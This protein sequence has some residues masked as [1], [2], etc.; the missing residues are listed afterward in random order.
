MRIKGSQ[1]I[2]MTERERQPERRTPLVPIDKPLEDSLRDLVAE[3]KVRH[4]ANDLA[5][6]A[7]ALRMVEME[8][9]V[10]GVV[11]L[12]SFGKG[13]MVVNAL[14]ILLIGALTGMFMWV[15]NDK[16]IDFR[17]V[18]AAIQQQ[19]VL[20][21]TNA[22]AEKI[23]AETLRDVVAEQKRTSDYVAG[24]VKTNTAAV[25]KVAERV[26]A[27]DDTANAKAANEAAAAKTRRT[28]VDRAMEVFGAEQQRQKEKLNRVV[29]P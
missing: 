6:A 1:G 23:K 2:R 13:L 3:E 29:K 11:K 24:L 19:A 14:V 22:D 21:A 28:E 7:N 18:Q 27:H 15:V 10:A 17:A 20:N 16:N 26:K 12:A 9:A 8:K 4:D 25:G 5:M